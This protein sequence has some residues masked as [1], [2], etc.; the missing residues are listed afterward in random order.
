M[1]D[2]HYF[3]RVRAQNSEG[4]GPLS[5]P[6]GFFTLPTAVPD[7]VVPGINSRSS[8]HL[9][10]TFATPNGNGSPVDEFQLRYREQGTTSYSTL[11]NVTSPTNILGL[12]PSTTY[13]V[14]VRAHNSAGWNDYQVTTIGTTSSPP[15]L[16]LSASNRTVTTG[17][18]VDWTLNSANG[19]TSPYTYVV[20][21]LPN[22][23]SFAPS[24]RR[25]TGSVS[26][27]GTTTVTYRVT[28]SAG[29]V[30]TVTFTITA[31][32]NVMVPGTP[33][34][35]NINSVGTT[36]A[37]LLWSAPSS[38]GSPITRVRRGGER[39]GTSSTS[40]YTSSSTS[41]V[42]TG[43][44]S[45]T[46]YRARV[47]AKNINGAGGFSGYSPFTTATASD[48]TP[49]PVNPTVSTRNGWAKSTAGVWQRVTSRSEEH[50]RSVGVPGD[51]GAELYRLMGEGRGLRRASYP[52]TA[53][54]PAL[55]WFSDNLF[56]TTSSFG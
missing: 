4:L 45:S 1:G 8:T 47:R 50:S 56:P 6:Y 27:S 10:I 55:E 29:T 24:T 23:L 19:G 32:T 14:Q 52:K 48:P 2:S 40:T 30:R 31:S 43:L 7:P 11:S 3:V 33:S 12:T 16:S 28:D 37:S 51:M 36:F 15:S 46:S 42:V 34:A 53:P 26:S 39:G 35:P 44:F 41:R 49:G 54:T 21:N 20:L 9:S 17:S 25:V 22:N 18:S 38:G 5:A 13:E